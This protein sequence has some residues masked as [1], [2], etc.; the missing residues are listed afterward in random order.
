MV[1][2][3]S[4]FNVGSSVTLRRNVIRQGCVRIQ[5][6]SYL[7]DNVIEDSQG[8]LVCSVYKTASYECLVENLT[9][10][11]ITEGVRA[12]GSSMGGWVDLTI[13][14]S[15]LESVN[16]GFIVT[17]RARISIY[18]TK[19]EVGSGS[20]LTGSNSWIRAYTTL[21][22]DNVYWKGGDLIVEGIL[23]M[24][25]ESQVAVTS[26]DMSTPAPQTILGWEITDTG[27]FAIEY[28]YP[29][30]NIEG[31]DFRADMYDL[32]SG[33]STVIEMV[34]NVFPEVEI[35][36]PS[37]M[38]GINASR[39]VVRGKYWELGSGLAHLEFSHNGTVF[40]KFYSFQEDRWN[41]SQY[42]LADGTYNLSVRGVDSVGNVGNIS[43]VMFV[44]DTV[45]P[46]L[47]IDPL[48]GLVNQTHVMVEGRTEPDSYLLINDQF[49]PISTDGCFTKGIPLEEGDNT[50]LVVVRDPAG[51]VNTATFHVLRDTVAPPLTITSP[52]NAT[53]TNALSVDIVGTTELGSNVSLMGEMVHLNEGDFVGSVALSEGNFHIVVSSQDKAGNLVKVVIILFVD[54]TTP[55]LTIA[56][57]ESNFVVT[58]E[59]ELWISGDID[60]PTIETV[61]INGKVEELFSGSFARLY[62]LLEGRNEFEIEVTDAAGNTNISHIVVDRD[63]SSPTYDEELTSIGGELVEVG[64]LLYSTAIVIEVHIVPDEAVIIVHRNGTLVPVAE[65]H[66]LRFHLTEGKNRVQFDI[67]DRVG[68]RGAAY[69]LEIFLDTTPPDIIL[70]EPISGY[71]TEYASIIFH[72]RTED[73]SEL[74]VGT[75]QVDLMSGGEFRR[76][77]DLEVGMNE[78]TIAVVDAMGN[79]N[80]TVISII[81]EEV[82]SEDERTSLVWIIGSTIAILAGCLL[83]GYI[84]IQRHRGSEQQHESVDHSISSKSE[85]PLE[86][87]QPGEEDSDV[88]EDWKEF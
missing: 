37:D 16:T 79:R 57:P 28:L 44:V 52:S 18:D 42:D 59:K 41:L 4:G 1:N 60:D 66:H 35:S 88:P 27:Q 22:P 15:S 45:V 34:D 6:S 5:G 32:W 46:T 74:V 87:S 64:G 78:I 85:V 7:E 76:S 67:E 51:N 72:G 69:D 70:F 48:P 75:T 8:G 26:I 77:V 49:I 38:E 82:E 68:N 54:W 2:C 14:N 12:S 61:T 47:I 62:V 30:L 73:G 58:R 43:Y 81:R 31:H 11:N 65:E 17:L 86:V 40:N 56:R 84:M 25:D 29:E 13:R 33:T 83:L 36:Y 20:V 80:S 39:L 24:K 9:L 53:W 55:G 19:L 3:Y 50:L 71:S 21:N 10:R 63:L 23:T